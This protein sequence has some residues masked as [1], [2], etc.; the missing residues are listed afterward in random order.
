MNSDQD[1][2]QRLLDSA[3]LAPRPL[4]VRAPMALE[5]RVMAHWRRLPF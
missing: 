1:P 5:T 2:L 3:A 4:P